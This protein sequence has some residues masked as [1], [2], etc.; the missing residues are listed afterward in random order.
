MATDYDF[1]EYQHE[2]YKKLWHSCE[3]ECWP[4]FTANAVATQAPDITYRSRFLTPDPVNNT[5][6]PNMPKIFD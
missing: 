3:K 4:V 5:A 2:L 1:V 6:P